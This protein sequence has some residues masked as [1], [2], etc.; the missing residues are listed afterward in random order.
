MNV[1]VACRESSRKVNMSQST[2]NQADMLNKFVLFTN[3]ENFMSYY[4]EFIKNNLSI[5]K[6]SSVV[7]SSTKFAACHRDMTADFVNRINNLLK[8]KL[9]TQV[10]HAEVQSNF[11]YML[12]LCFCAKTETVRNQLIS[13][14]DSNSLSYDNSSVSAAHTSNLQITYEDDED[15]TNFSDS[16]NTLCIEHMNT[17]E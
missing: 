5:G 17:P 2:S 9:I 6:N 7:S 12:H 11:Y 14:N 10:K 4:N 13:S 3:Q 15:V 8:S 1:M 16:F